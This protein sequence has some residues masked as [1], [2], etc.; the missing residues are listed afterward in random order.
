MSIQM[1]VTLH[2]TTRHHIPKYSTLR[3]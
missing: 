2:Q 3:D 1:L